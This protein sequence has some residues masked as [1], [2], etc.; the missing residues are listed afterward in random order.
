MLI[1]ADSREQLPLE[2]IQTAGVSVVRDA[3][4]VGDYS[5]II[6]GNL[7]PIRWERKSIA[8]LFSSFSSGYEAEKAKILKAQA[9]G[10]RYILAIEGSASEVRK[11]HAYVKDGEVHESKKSGISQLKQLCTLNHKYGVELAFCQSRKD[12]ALLITES[13]LA[14]E[15]LMLTKGAQDGEVYRG[16]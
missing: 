16:S 4:D 14:L 10:Y 8:D 9:L 12:M 3:L 15:R 7:V 2:F 1:V 11:G 13:F 6:G 5:A